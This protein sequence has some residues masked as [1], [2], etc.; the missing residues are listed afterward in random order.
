M[1][2]MIVGYDYFHYAQSV[3]NACN[4]MGH[5]AMRLPVYKF[6]EV[7]RQQWKIRMVKLGFRQFEQVYE[8]K[9]DNDLIEKIDKFNPDICIVLNGNSVS[10][11][12]LSRIKERKIKLILFMI[13]SIQEENLQK[14]IS[15]M[16][17]YDKIFS[18]ESTDGL[19][20]PEL[21]INYMFIGYDETLFNSNQDDKSK[22]IDISFIGLLDKNRSDLLER[23]AEYAFKCGK[24]FFV[25]TKPYKQNHIFH[26]LKNFFKHIKFKKRYPY[27]SKV[28]LNTV[29]CNH[30]LA[31][32]YKRSKI[33][34]NIHKESGSHTDV[35]PRTFEILGCKT[36]QLIDQGHLKNIELKSGDHLVEYINE[37][38]LCEKINY[39]LHH[40]TE[41][42]AIA[43]AGQ[44]LVQEKYTMKECVEKILRE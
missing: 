13:D 18:Y 9:Q 19:I 5:Q 31:D 26:K 20:C 15:Q 39:Y 42:E 22:D 2:I 24:S 16:F 1:K 36:F 33:C 43:L 44:Q 4:L 7:E 11:Y 25:H 6:S 14:F 17:F 38:D 29:V 37:R 10:K 34:I 27:L 35:N 21:D 12:V 28:L 3:V 32:V 41:R 8:Q 40:E 23:V 30:D